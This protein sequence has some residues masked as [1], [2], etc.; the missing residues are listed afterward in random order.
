VKVNLDFWTF[1]Y[2]FGQLVAISVA[3]RLGNS[4]HTNQ[5]PNITVQYLE[6]LYQTSCYEPGT[7]IFSDPVSDYVSSIETGCQFLQDCV[8]PHGNSSKALLLAVHF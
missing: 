5:L 7:A 2:W 4:M 8:F 3:K 1:C 6:A